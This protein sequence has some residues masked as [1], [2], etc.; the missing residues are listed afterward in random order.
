LQLTELT[1][2]DGQQAPIQTQMINRNGSTSTG[3]DAAAIGGTT[4][5]GAIIGAGADY[6]RGAAI[7][8][9]AGA[10]A[11]IIGVLLTRGRPTVIYPESVLTFRVEAP[12]AISTE[13]APQAFRYVDPQDYGRAPA[14][15]ARQSVAPVGPPPPPPAP[16]YYGYAYPYPYYSPGISVYVGPRYG[17]Y[18][19]PRFRG[20]YRRW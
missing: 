13:R 1:L 14:V 12:V 3:R 15:S 7:G 11:G 20:G 10:A 17:Y 16:R 4:A 18:Y 2:V 19:G 9:G 6:G 8:A 5:L